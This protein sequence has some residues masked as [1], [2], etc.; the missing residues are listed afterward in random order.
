VN[1]NRNLNLTKAQ[2][3]SK[4]RERRILQLTIKEVDALKPD[5]NVYRGIGKM[6]VQSLSC[7]FK[8]T[9]TKQVPTDSSSRDGE[10]S[11]EAGKGALG[12]PGHVE[13]K[14]GHPYRHI[15]IFTATY[16]FWALQ[17]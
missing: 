1:A 15:R 5:V 12:R 16:D 17:G 3:A 9:E 13:Q 10:R 11:Q 6:C 7:W 14:G 2:I 8:F 4:E